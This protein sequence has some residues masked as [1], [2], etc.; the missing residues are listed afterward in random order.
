M[1]IRPPG[2]LDSPLLLLLTSLMLLSVAPLHAS[3]P[4]TKKPNFI[5]ILAEA[6]GW[7]SMSSPQDDRHPEASTSSIIRTPHL[8]ALAKRGM[9]F[10]DFYAASPRCTP[11][12]AALFTGR[13]PASLHMTFVHEGRKAPVVHPS[14]KTIGPISITQLPTDIPTIGSLLQQQG[15][16]TAHFGKWHCG[17]T[18]PSQHGFEHHDGPNGNG[19]PDNVEDPNPKQAYAIAEKGIQFITA[20]SASGQPF[21]LQLSQYPSRGPVTA[22]LDTIES[23][24]KRLGTRIGYQRIGIAAGA[25]EIDKTLGLLFA[26]LAQLNL[27]DNTYLIYTSDHGAQGINA[28]GGLS[29]GKGSVWEGGLRVPL[30]IAGPGISPN[31]FTHV[32]ASTVDLL[33]TVL[34]LAGATRSQLPTHLEGTS[35]ASTLLNNPTPSAIRQHEEFVVHFPHHDKDPLGPA[36]AIYSGKYKLIHFYETG[37]LKLFDLSTDVAEQTDV[38]PQQ[39]EMVQR[40]HRLLT[41]HLASVQAAMPTANPDYDYDS[42]N[43]VIGPGR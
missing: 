17:R 27:L 26:K 8:D 2:S 28:N 40:L 7:A 11:T 39:S 29:Q 37:D 41:D 38:G 1:N 31:S 34:H 24:K 36:S 43:S 12:R 35:L 20:Q 22:R 25:E 10:S 30:I 3:V 33:P 16:T 13:S 5:V 23:V 32:R 9:R 19:G 15:Y 4:L 18:Q 14:Q 6:Q 42:G 21:Y